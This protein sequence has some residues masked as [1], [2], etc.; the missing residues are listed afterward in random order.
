[1]VEQI[2]KAHLQHVYGIDEDEHATKLEP[3]TSDQA[4]TILSVES[5]AT[6]MVT[7]TKREETSFTTRAF[8]GPA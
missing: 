6:D 5:A 3:I 1:M 8:T 7:I 4:T 2:G